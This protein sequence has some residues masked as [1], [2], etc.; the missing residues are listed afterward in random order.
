MKTKVLTLIL[1]NMQVAEATGANYVAVTTEYTP[2]GKPNYTY[3]VKAASN[4]TNWLVIGVKPEITNM[5]F[6]FLNIVNTICNINNLKAELAD[7]AQA[8][9]D[10]CDTIITRDDLNELCLADA[11]YQAINKKLNKAKSRARGY[12]WEL[13]STRLVLDK[14]NLTAGSAVNLYL[15]RF[16]GITVGDKYFYLQE[17]TPITDS[18]FSEAYKWKYRYKIDECTIDAG[19]IIKEEIPELVTSSDVSIIKAYVYA[20][21]PSKYIEY[22][23]VYAHDINT[24]KV[25]AYRREVQMYMLD[26]FFTIFDNN[27][28]LVAEDCQTVRKHMDDHNFDAND[29]IIYQNKPQFVFKKSFI[30]NNLIWTEKESKETQILTFNVDKVSKYVETN[31]V[32]FEVQVFGDKPIIGSVDKF[33]INKSLKKSYKY[34]KDLYTIIGQRHTEDDVLM[35]SDRINLIEYAKHILGDIQLNIEDYFIDLS[36]PTDERRVYFTRGYVQACYN[37]LDYAGTLY[38]AAETIAFD[39]FKGAIRGYLPFVEEYSA[40]DD[41][42]VIYYDEND[43]GGYLVDSNNDYLNK[44][45]AE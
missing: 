42:R 37:I 31:G 38:N 13:Y 23:D 12:S 17:E 8:I 4:N 29:D 36:D 16:H 32:D 39:S 6:A 26:P 22:N 7:R 33:Y 30:P 1:A 5:Y 18:L 3:N 20:T 15:N 14:G 28:A 27:D 44:K 43:K 25:Y 40:G 10:S 35:V 34:I 11:E 9:L 41:F 19:S 45:G 24:K 2:N 21:T